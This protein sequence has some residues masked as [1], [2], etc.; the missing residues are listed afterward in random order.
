MQNLILSLLLTAT[1][2]AQEVWFVPV[3]MESCGP[4]Q[5]FNQEYRNPMTGLRTWLKS[6]VVTAHAV[7]VGRDQQFAHD[8][9]IPKVP[10]FLLVDE[11]EQELARIEGYNGS[12]W[13]KQQVSQKLREIQTRRKS[14]TRSRTT[15]KVET[16]FSLPQCP[17][18]ALYC[19]QPAPPVEIDLTPIELRLKRLEGH[20]VAIRDANYVTG[21]QL[22]D[23]TR[24]ID[25]QILN[26]KDENADLQQRVEALESLLRQVQGDVATIR[27]R[28]RTVKLLDGGKEIDSETYGADE[29]IILDLKA[30]TKK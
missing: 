29:P 24:R 8:W 28:K 11:N 21:D 14:V 10:C 20:L 25:D 15:Q 9:K 19:P 17:P 23:E 3:K 22:E 7:D 12:V 18:G 27:D 16:Q 26:L 13:L 1:C 6:K 2:A 30:I 5:R 4:C